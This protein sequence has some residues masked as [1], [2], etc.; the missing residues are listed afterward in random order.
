MPHDSYV[1]VFHDGE[2]RTLRVEHI[3]G[4]TVTRMAVAPGYEDYY[5]IDLSEEQVRALIKVLESF[6]TPV[7]GP[8]PPTPS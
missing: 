4:L 8:T 6:L 7:A 5:S 2:Y 3:G 1:A